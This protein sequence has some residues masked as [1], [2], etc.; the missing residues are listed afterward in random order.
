MKSEASNAGKNLIKTI[1]AALTRQNVI[2]NKK[3]CHGLDSFYESSTAK[4]S[5][6]FT[7]VKPSPSKSNNISNDKLTPQKQLNKR[8]FQSFPEVSGNLLNIDT[9]FV[10]TFSKN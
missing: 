2:I 5:I 6:Y 9:S 7:I 1:I 4:Q 10:E 8:L 3:I